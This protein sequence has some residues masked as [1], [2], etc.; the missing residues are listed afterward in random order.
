[1]TNPR[2]TKAIAE[3]TALLDPASGASPI[4]RP[5]REDDIEMTFLDSFKAVQRA[6]SPGATREALLR[7]AA[8]CAWWAAR[9]DDEPLPPNGP[10]R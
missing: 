10:R 2:L 9:N 3:I 5:Y 6:R 8:F 1:M 7:L 4:A